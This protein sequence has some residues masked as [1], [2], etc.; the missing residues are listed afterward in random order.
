MVLIMPADRLAG[1]ARA[2][3]VFQP[4]YLCVAL[5]PHQANAS[6]WIQLPGQRHQ[7]LWRVA[8]F[9]PLPHWGRG[10]GEG[11]HNQRIAKRL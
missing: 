10:Q 11:A 1:Q 6:N 7:P 2:L 5:E 8:L 9:I 4:T 3:T